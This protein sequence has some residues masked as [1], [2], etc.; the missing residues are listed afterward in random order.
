MVSPGSLPGER[1]P[2]GLSMFE[3]APVVPRLRVFMAVDGMASDV[4]CE[5]SFFKLIGAWAFSK[6]GGGSVDGK[7]DEGHE[8]NSGDGKARDV[9]VRLR[10]RDVSNSHN[11]RRGEDPDNDR[12]CCN[13]EQEFHGVGRLFSMLVKTPAATEH[14]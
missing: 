12:V 13:L 7:R 11:R 3:A 8:R 1:R 4:F 6:H 5:K 9:D 10:G 2:Q 14:G